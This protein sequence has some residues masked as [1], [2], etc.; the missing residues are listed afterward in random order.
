M[1]KDAKKGQQEKPDWEGRRL[2]TTRS[3]PRQAQISRYCTRGGPLKNWR[4]GGWSSESAQCI[5]KSV[6]GDQGRLGWVG[7][8]GGLGSCFLS[9]RPRPCTCPLA[10][11]KARRAS[12]RQHAGWG[13]HRDNS[14]KRDARKKEG[15]RGETKKKRQDFVTVD[16]KPQIL[17]HPQAKHLVQCAFLPH[18][19]RTSSSVVMARPSPPSA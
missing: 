6:S 5:V 12:R 8:F 14:R 3:P 19:R 1:R 10:P 9:A 7:G 11:C 2:G 13:A 15:V 4:G 18:H 17:A 16:L